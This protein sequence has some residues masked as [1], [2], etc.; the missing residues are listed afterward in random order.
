MKYYELNKDEEAVLS[1][2]EADK[3]ERIEDL[4]A[5]IISV[6]AAARLNLN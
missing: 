6:K 5:N 4:E 3:L 2:F 1:E